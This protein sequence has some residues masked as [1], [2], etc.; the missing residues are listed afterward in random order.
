M[1]HDV[2]NL[3]KKYLPKGL[4]L[5]YPNPEKPYTLFT[6]ASKYAWACV[7][8]KPYTHVIDCREKKQSLIWSHT[9]VD[10]LEAV[11][12]TGLPWLS[13]HVLTTCLSKS[14]IWM[15]LISF[16]EV[17]IF[18]YENSWKRIPWIPMSTTGPWKLSNTKLN[19]S[20]LKVSKKTD[21]RVNW[22]SFTL[23]YTSRP[24]AWRIR[25][26]ALP[27]NSHLMFLQCKMCHIKLN[28]D[29]NEIT[30]SPADSA[31]H[32]EIIITCEKLHQLQ[33]QD[34]FCKGIWKQLQTSRLQ[35]S[36]PYFI[37]N[38]LLMSNVRQNKQYLQTIVLQRILVTQLLRLADDHLGHNVTTKTYTLIRRL[39]YWKGPSAS[40]SKY[41]K[42]CLT[43]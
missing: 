40:V 15:M 33:Q 25:I 39:L 36:N 20:I 27:L 41:I 16:S 22:L 10:C 8:I 18:L 17:A 42:Q 19:F 21:T 28:T 6:N 2:L 13:R 7:L 12:S 43:W 29:V 14:F 35:S 26:M 34:H 9:W 3:L 38:E 4:I 1:Y 31:V 37:E 23:M 5:K 24:W 32:I 11:N 30:S